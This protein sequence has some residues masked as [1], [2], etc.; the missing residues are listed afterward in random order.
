MLI[1]RIENDN[2]LGPY[3]HHEGQFSDAYP[4]MCDHSDNRHPSPWHSSSGLSSIYEFEYCGFDS[5]VSLAEWFADYLDELDSEGFWVSVYE[6]DARVGHY[7]QALFQRECATKV[8]RQP[9]KI[10]VESLT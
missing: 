6:S 9:I 5:I 1:Y 7:G 10:L 3:Q 8:D 4:M 2:G